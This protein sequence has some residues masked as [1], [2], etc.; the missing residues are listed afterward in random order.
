MMAPRID[1]FHENDA[2][3][4]DLIGHIA[5]AFRAKT[6]VLVPELNSYYLAV[7]QHEKQTAELRVYE[8]LP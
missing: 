1:V 7:P 5:T 3:H 8:V 2:D 6:G 4:Y